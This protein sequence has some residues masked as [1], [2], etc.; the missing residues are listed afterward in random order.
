MDRKLYR[1]KA[2][3]I[4]ILFVLQLV[5]V[6]FIDLHAQNYWD[7]W[8][9]VRIDE[10][11]AKQDLPFG[12]LDANGTYITHI[13]LIS[14]LDAGSYEVEIESYDYG[15]LYHIKNT[16]TYLTFST[17]M[18]YVGYGQE[19]ILVINSYGGGYFYKNPD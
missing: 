5:L 18:G 2:K 13:F 14:E 6:S 8:D 9:D 11:F 1:L 15:D 10:I 4:S 17:Y 12:S 19:G 7:D 3:V 16:D